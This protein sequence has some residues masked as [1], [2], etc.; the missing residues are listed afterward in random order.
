M[1]YP[2]TE[3]Q[4]TQIERLIANSRSKF[5]DK[6]KTEIYNN[7]LLLFNS[8]KKSNYR[9]FTPQDL[10]YTKIALDIVFYGIEFLDYKTE[11]E[12]PKRLIFCLNKVLN[13]WIT[14]GT[15]TYFIVV[16][17]NRTPDNFFIRGYD[18]GRLLTLKLLFR[19]LFNIDY[20][21][22]LIQIS[23]PQFLSN[24]YL[25]GVPLYHELGHFIDRNY[26]IIYNFSREPDFILHG[27]TEV[28][29]SEFF[30]DLFAA[31]YIG[32]SALA[33]LDETS[34]RVTQTHPSIAK[35]V[36][37]VNTFIQGTGSL[38]CM[39][40]VNELK[41]VT[42]LRTGKDLKIRYEDFT[43]TENPFLTLTPRFFTDPQK[44]HCLFNA[45]WQCWLDPNSILRTKHPVHSDCSNV[46]SKLIK[47]SIKLTMQQSEL[48]KLK[49]VGNYIGNIASKYGFIDN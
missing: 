31:Q 33:P 6:K 46:I 35:R 44:L 1:Q 17:Y 32:S 15:D 7:L 8:I 42:L 13:D 29:F 28:H 43:D 22:S 19:T 16:S 20:S 24:D 26:Q 30:A 38:E 37:V 23:K 48:N 39:T 5:S 12:I 40:I 18:Q 11:N 45:G 25:S 27:I 36:E 14:N 47:G 49:K 2:K 10:F 34:T 4:I 3:L 21:Q 41:R 9:S